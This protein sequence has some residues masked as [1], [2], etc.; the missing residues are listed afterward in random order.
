MDAFK[1]I[2][3]ILK[4]L[5]ATMN[6]NEFPIEQFNSETFKV[7]DQYFS[8]VLSMLSKDGYIEGVT[9]VPILGQTC[10]GLKFLKPTITIKGLEYLQENSMM[11]KAANIAK[12]IIDVLT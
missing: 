6:V 8:T 10:Y 4:F 5:E 12:G 3:K 11:K 9:F 2:Y 7:S 1:I